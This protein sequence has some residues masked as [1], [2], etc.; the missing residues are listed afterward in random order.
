MI[1]IPEAE[2]E[3]A[4]RA[5]CEAFRGVYGREPTQSERTMARVKIV[6][7]VAMGVADAVRLRRP[8]RRRG[9]PER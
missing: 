5:G 2:V 1:T 8:P 9:Q 3:H 4:V 7:A 6:M